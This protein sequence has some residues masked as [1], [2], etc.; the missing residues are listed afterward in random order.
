MAGACG[1]GAAYPGSSSDNAPP[2]PPPLCGT[3][4]VASNP[5]LWGLQL[6]VAGR[7]VYYTAYGA[8][9]DGHEHQLWSVP[10]GGGEPSLLWQGPSGILGNGLLL[11]DGQAYLS[12]ELS[13]NTGNEGV[14]TVPLAGG[15]ATTRGT[16]GTACAAYGGMVMDDTYV[17]AGSNGCGVGAGQILAVP[18]AGGASSVLWTGNANGVGA[19]AMALHGGVLYFL[20]DDDGDG[21]GELMSLGP[22]GT[23]QTVATG[24]DHEVHGL[25]ADDAGLY[26]TAGEALYLLPA[27][28]SRSVTLASGLLH[29][30]LLAVD[31]GGIY[32]AEGNL[33]DGPIGSVVRVAHEPQNGAAPTVL[34]SGQPAIFALAID[35]SAVY[36]ASQT[37]R[38]VMRAGKCN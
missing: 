36:W 13:W 17:Y 4:T 10:T 37:G 21:D 14:M 30:G 28:G 27:G 35:D 7:Q 38:V 32:L 24:I 2:A 15:P 8:G 6:A 12:S 23:A 11:A 18:R 19:S 16:F 22:G 1:G 31:A 33:A 3:W 9:P 5:T 34:A 25:A 29:P 26:F 20:L